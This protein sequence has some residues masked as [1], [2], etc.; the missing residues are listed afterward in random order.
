MLGGHGGNIYEISRRIGCS[1]EKIIDMSS[2]INPLGPPPGL[3]EHLK[4]NISAATRLPEVDGRE[5][6][7]HFAEFLDIDCDRLLSG[8]G[9]TQFIYSIPQVLETRKALILGPTYSDYADACKLHHVPSTLVMAAESA[10]FQP[11]TE[12]LKKSLKKV[13]TVFLCNPNN[14]TGSLLARDDL[15][16]ICRTHLQTNFVVDESYLPF[17]SGGEKESM[18]TSNLSNVIV[19]LSISKI[20]AIPG[21]RVGFVVAA[22]EMIEKFRRYLLP[23]S[24]N[25]LA[26]AAVHYL[27]ENKNFIRTFIFKTRR[28]IHEE[29]K[30]FDTSLKHMSLLKLYPSVTPFFLA[31]LPKALTADSLWTALVNDKILIRNCS[32]FSGLSDRFIRISLKAPQANQLLASKLNALM[33]HST[34]LYESTAKKRTAGV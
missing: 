29:R 3:L 34:A 2:N 12:R 18:I 9:T 20:F 5:T 14:P 33:L 28:F 15:L 11:D 19:L 32:N 4:C 27:T 16:E 7:K 1:S 21:L 8:N 24:V 25:S 22:A 6:I 17:V 10:D 31:R 23:W 30:A 13:D 26:Q